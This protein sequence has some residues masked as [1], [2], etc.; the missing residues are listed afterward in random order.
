[1]VGGW[2][3]VCKKERLEKAKEKAILWP[4]FLHF[5]KWLMICVWNRRKTELWSFHN[6][7][8][9]QVCQQ[10]TFNSTTWVEVTISYLQNSYLKKKHLYMQLAGCSS[11]ACVCCMYTYLKNDNFAALWSICFMWITCK[12]LLSSEYPLCT[13][14][15][16]FQRMWSW[17][18]NFS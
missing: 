18:S 7:L 12:A 5:K 3:H 6:L 1:M 13:C 14:I 10:E 4:H 17:R 9:S 15:D 8:A 2:D 16:C 11:P